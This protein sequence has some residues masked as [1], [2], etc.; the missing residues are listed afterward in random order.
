[1]PAFPLESLLTG[2][3]LSWHLV[4]QMYRTMLLN[5][6]TWRMTL[7]IDTGCQIRR[8]MRGQKWDMQ[9]KG[10]SHGSNRWHL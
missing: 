2:V 10:T 8:W 6:L 1:M 5:A 9:W 7:I 3:Q 4:V